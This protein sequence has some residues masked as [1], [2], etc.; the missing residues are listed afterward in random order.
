VQA[1]SETVEVVIV[2][3]FTPSRVPLLDQRWAVAPPEAAD[4]R[5]VDGGSRL[6]SGTQT[7]VRWSHV[8]AGYEYSLSYFDGFNHLPNIEGHVRFAPGGLVLTRVHP[9]ITSYGVDAA[10]PTRWFTIKG[11][12]AYFASSAPAT[13]EYI[14]YVLQLERQTGEWFLV[15][16]Y[17]GEVVTERNAP[18]TFAPDRGMTRAVVGRASYTIDANRTA[19]VEAAVRQNGH[20]A[21]VKAEYSQ[22]RG[23][24]WRMTAA[25]SVIVGRAGDFL[26]QYRRNSHLSVA[27]RYSF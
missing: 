22:A 24:H 5:L 15:A 4:I 26:G 6:P 27:L 14:L 13:D 21:Y 3:R 2:P 11:E 23:Q 8:G 16:G 12:S 7:G 1:G 9:A 10:V 18:L 25:G 19:A 17:A 20:G